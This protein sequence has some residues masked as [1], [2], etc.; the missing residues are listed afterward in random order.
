MRI[1]TY[2]CTLILICCFLFGCQE[3]EY[4]ITNSD[5]FPYKDLRGRLVLMPHPADSN[6]IILGFGKKTDKLDYSELIALRD[7]FSN[8]LISCVDSMG[9]LKDSIVLCVG[10]VSDYWENDRLENLYK[11]DG[12]EYYVKIYLVKTKE[13]DYQN[14]YKNLGGD[15]ISMDLELN[16]E[17][18]KRYILSI[19]IE[20]KVQFIENT[21]S[22]SYRL[23]E[24]ELLEFMS[25]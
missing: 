1:Y 25:M 13:I 4:V 6:D 5:M 11:R 9:V 21:Q 12:D 18:W 14:V 7:C 16:L 23:L 15:T 8:E 20:N 19:D 17:D 10:E 24:L 2:I 3:P 22:V